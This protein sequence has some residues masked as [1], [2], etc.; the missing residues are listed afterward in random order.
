V[1]GDELGEPCNRRGRHEEC[2]Q[3]F[4]PETWRKEFILMKHE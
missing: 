2:V 1:K 4:S 3:N